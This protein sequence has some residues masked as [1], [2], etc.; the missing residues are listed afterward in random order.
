MVRSEKYAN[1]RCQ[2]VL[3]DCLVS[4]K[5]F[6]MYTNLVAH[7]WLSVRLL[8]KKGDAAASPFL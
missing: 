3:F 6:E 7:L 1:F 8:N 4:D 2:M 5:V